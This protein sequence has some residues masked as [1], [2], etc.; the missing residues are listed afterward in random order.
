MISPVLHREVAREDRE[1]L[2]LLEA[3]AIA[4]RVVDDSLEQLADALVGGQR[5]YVAVDAVLRGPAPD[6]HRRRA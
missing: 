3:G 2:D 5:R 6:L 1:P 4:V